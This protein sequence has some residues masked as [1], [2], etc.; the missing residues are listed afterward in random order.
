LFITL[1]IS[2]FRTVK[3]YTSNTLESIN[4]LSFQS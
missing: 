4:L 2:L 3:R 1:D